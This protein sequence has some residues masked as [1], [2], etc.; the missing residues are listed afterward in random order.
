MLA[1]LPRL[2]HDLLGLLDRAAMRVPGLGQ[3]F[4][5][6][7]HVWHLADIEREAFGVRIERILAEEVPRLADFDGTRIAHERDYR[8]RDPALGVER[9]AA[10]RAATIARLA[11]VPRGALART[12]ILAGGEM[13]ALAGMTEHI[14]AHDRAHA[15]ELAAL[16]AA[17]GAIVPGALVAFGSGAA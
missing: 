5:Y 6:I 10:A 14:L 11:A 9:F 3:E 1:Q 17:R 4:C 13:L 16:V 7:E 12:G 2:V 8:S 15:T